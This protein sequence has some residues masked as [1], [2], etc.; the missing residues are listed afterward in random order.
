MGS[1]GGCSFLEN[2]Y[3]GDLRIPVRISTVLLVREGSTVE[4]NVTT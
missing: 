2:I 3:S 4:C 1:E